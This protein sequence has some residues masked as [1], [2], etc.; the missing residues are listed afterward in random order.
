VHI[1]RSEWAGGGHFDDFVERRAATAIDPPT[2]YNI[3]RVQRL[4]GEKV[5]DALVRGG[6]V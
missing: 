2:A 1:L 5:Q 4:G 6:G 3:Y